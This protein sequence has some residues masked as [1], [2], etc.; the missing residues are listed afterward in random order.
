MTVAD[1]FQRQHDAEQMRALLESEGW[2]CFQRYLQA[3]TEAAL[4]RLLDAPVASF[5]EV[6][7][8]YHGLRR[9]AQLPHRVIDAGRKPD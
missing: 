7:G 2:A 6:R 3:E 5:E 1:R 4:S 9:A 8:V